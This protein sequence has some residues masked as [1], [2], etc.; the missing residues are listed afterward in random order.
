MPIKNEKPKTGYVHVNFKC[1]KFYGFDSKFEFRNGKIIIG[2]LYLFVGVFVFVVICFL[3]GHHIEARSM[4][5][6]VAETRISKKDEFDDREPLLKADLDDHC[7]LIIQKDTPPEYTYPQ[8]GEGFDSLG[9][10]P[11]S[12]FEEDVTLVFHDDHGSKESSTDN[13]ALKI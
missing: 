6:Q 7:D 4:T 12:K 11:E 8:K 9:V 13:N 3:L 5:K 10:K 2:D 1:P